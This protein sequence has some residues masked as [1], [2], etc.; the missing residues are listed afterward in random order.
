MVIIKAPKILPIVIGVVISVVG[1][2]GTVFMI[3][4]VFTRAENS[5]PL[6]VVVSDIGSNSVKVNWTT[7]QETQGIVIYGL[8]P[9]ALNF[10]APETTKVTSHSVDLTL[11]AP[12]TTYYFTIKIGDKENNNGGVPWTFNTKSSGQTGVTVPQTDTS[13]KTPISSVDTDIEAASEVDCS[14][15]DC[16]TIKANL[17]KCTTVD[18]L[19]CIRKLTPKP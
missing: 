18:Y 4:N 17:G 13:G 6:D 2:I 19:K 8:S 1:L 14:G 3:Q 7:N 15:T 12:N 9:T 16:Q 11:L 5:I 10:F